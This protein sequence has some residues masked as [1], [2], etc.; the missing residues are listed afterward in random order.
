MNA[1]DAIFALLIVLAMLRGYSKGLLGTAAAYVAPVAGFMI[2]ADASSPVRDRLAE[3]TTLPDIV[4]DMLAPVLV[5]VV[6]VIAVRFAAAVFARVLGLGLSMPSRILASTASMVVS[7][8][9]LGSLVVLV[10]HLKPARQP[11]P[12]SSLRDEN[13]EAGEVL[14]TPL[15]K[16]V[17]DLD[18]RFSESMLAP[19]LAELASA[20]I[21][22]AMARH[23]NSPLIGREEVEAVAKQATDAAA[24]V[25][26]LP[27][28]MPQRDDG[29]TR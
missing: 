20:V 18:R 28:G 24:A 15:A 8:L 9:V 19:P 6:V 22:E 21:S 25:G 10:Q 5:F 27:I 11:A 14:V 17:L 16:V 23:P 26:K 13:G 29:R 3:A 1:V 2:A 12:P 4:L 7:A